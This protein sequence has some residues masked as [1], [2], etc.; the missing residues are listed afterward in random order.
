M[1]EETIVFRNGDFSLE[2]VLRYPDLLKKP[3]AC[4][5]LIHGTM[6][7][8]RDGD[9]LKT[10]DNKNVH[11]KN[12]LALSKKLT[13]VGIATFSWDKRGY[14]KSQGEP[15]DYFLQAQDAKTALDAICLRPNIVDAAKIAVFGQSAGVHVAC[16][17]AKEETRPC[18]Y[19]LSGGLYSSYWDMMSFNYH[20]V[21][22]YAQKSPENLAWVEKNDLWGLVSGI[23]LYRKFE[24]IQR[25]DK[26]FRM[27]YKGQSW[28]VPLDHKTYLPE[29][30]P[31][32]QFKYIKQPALVI[33][34][35][36]D[37]NV[38]VQDAV[39]IE[40]EL[41]RW[42]NVHVK[43]VIIPNADHSFQ[44]AAPDEDTRIKE[45]MSFESF[46]RP[47][48]EAYYQHIIA[49]LKEQFRE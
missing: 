16:L 47:Y 43:R 8:D 14:G 7:H 23:N 40:A 46:K 22:D 24:A 39:C 3:A 48:V 26:E 49:F 20:R 30:E 34:G 32:N 5:I 45:R 33:H 28:I 15:G 11:K 18:A 19:V 2:G 6:E 25:G 29:H 9:L 41:K 10:P 21:R 36:A 35:D 27:E 12:F 37:L 42:G 44:Q 17:L 1:R 4:M 13:A 31:R 38:K